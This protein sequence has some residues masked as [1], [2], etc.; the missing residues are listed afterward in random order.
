MKL[1]EQLKID[2]KDAMRTKDISRRDSIRAINTMIKQVEV[3]ERRDINDTEIIGL[4]QKGIKS[5]NES[6]VQYK[7][8]KR[9]DLIEKEQAQ[10]DI[11]TLYL[12]KQLSD[13]E[14]KTII[15]DI[16]SKVEDAITAYQNQYKSLENFANE[17]NFSSMNEFN[18]SFLIQLKH[19]DF[20]EI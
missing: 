11:F 9:D 3:D 4:I 16:I 12:P 1:K 17:L 19:L 6:I 14:L 20:E 8:A 18:N 7:E 15:E 2:L 13:D 10:I 5:R